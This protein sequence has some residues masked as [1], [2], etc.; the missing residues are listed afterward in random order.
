M[1]RY[2]ELL[3]KAIDIVNKSGQGKLTMGESLSFIEKAEKELA[4]PYPEPVAYM[5]CNGDVV[6]KSEH[7]AGS[8]RFTIPL[9]TSPPQQ[10][11]LTNEEIEE[12]TQD[13]DV[14]STFYI[15]VARA[16]EK[17]HGIGN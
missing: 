13:I 2:R 4:K 10:K 12:I 5:G 11:P 15:D 7:N 3:E 8:K 1:S 6:S 9:Y 17:A 14:K 16:I